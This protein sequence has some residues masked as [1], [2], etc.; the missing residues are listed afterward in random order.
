MIVPF[1]IDPAALHPPGVQPRQLVAAHTRL[2]E[3]WLQRGLLVTPTDRPNP[4]KSAIAGLPQRLRKRWK[5]AFR[6]ARLSAGPDGWR[7]LNRPADP[8]DLEPI[9]HCVKL[10]CVDDQGAEAL[11]LDLDDFSC[12][13]LDDRIEVVPFLQSDMATSFQ[14]ASRVASSSIEAKTPTAAVWARRFADLARHSRSIGAMDLYAIHNACQHKS[15]GLRRLLSEL[16]RLGEPRELVLFSSCTGATPGTWQSD[17]DRLVR[18]AAPVRLTLYV[19]PYS[20]R[21]DYHARYLRFGQSLCELELGLE[22]LQGRR[23]GRPQAFK[24]RLVQ[25]SDKHRERDA[26]QLATAFRFPS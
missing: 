1:A 22:V 4:L 21:Y 11:G 2:L 15:S 10:A 5:V 12:W 18:A 17:V 20:K 23:T 26:L 16:S 13:I 19:I 25:P 8:A 14:E 9:A 6:T 3:Q 7:G 24:H